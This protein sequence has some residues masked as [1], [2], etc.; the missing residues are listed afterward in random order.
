GGH[1]TTG[2]LPRSPPPDIR[3]NADTFEVTASRELLASGG[4]IDGHP[5]AEFVVIGVRV[6]PVRLFPDQPS[7][8]AQRP[9]ARARANVP[10]GGQPSAGRRSTR[11]L[12]QR[13]RALRGR[14]T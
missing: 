2:L 7:P 5:I 11:V 1:G 8:R 3:S 9:P 12:F 13:R 6:R 10:A 14:Q 4:D